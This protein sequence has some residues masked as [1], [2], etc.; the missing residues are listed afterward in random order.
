MS[1]SFFVESL[2][3]GSPKE[4]YPTLGDSVASASMLTYPPHCLSSYL[5]SLS[6]AQQ[7][8]MT[9][10]RLPFFTTNCKGPRP[11]RPIPRP[12]APSVHTIGH[13]EQILATTPPELHLLSSPT[14]SCASS[15]RES[16]SPP[17]LS[18]SKH[19]HHDTSSK[20][21]RTAFTSK[22]LL[23]LEKAFIFNKYLSR[24]RRIEI[25]NRLQL[26]EKQVKIWFQNR[27][28]KHK[29]EEYP[30]DSSHPTGR[31]CCVTSRT[32][33]TVTSKI[34]KVETDVDT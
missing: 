29:K 22:Q 26:S 34:E 5:F 21:I 17:P 13:P 32:I 30:N 18:P 23:E 24:L 3:G 11:V 8:Q 16:P 25:A 6:L 20:R 10:Q 4:P 14:D 33:P 12:T 9:A 15:K 31:C 27:R 1:K 19:A 28:V 2:I 7:Q